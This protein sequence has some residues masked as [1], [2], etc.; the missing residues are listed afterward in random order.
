[1][2][3]EFKGNQRISAYLDHAELTERGFTI[4]DYAKNV[5]MINDLV[6]ELLL[7]AE[8]TQQ[9]SNDLPF[10]TEVS[11]VPGEGAFITVTMLQDAPELTESEVFITAVPTKDNLVFHFKD[12]ED[13]ISCGIRLAD[14]PEIDGQLFLY[15]DKY[16]V[17]L[18]KSQSIEEQ[19]LAEIVSIMEEYAVHAD[20]TVSLL[21]EYGKSLVDNH[22]FQRFAVYFAS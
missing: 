20:L 2:K 1:M 17:V 4:G 19:A 18:D 8:S 3:I 7:F 15:Q 13:L 22:L 9:F 14:T 21:Q 10:K 12:V 5:E 11:Y 6:D 16:Y